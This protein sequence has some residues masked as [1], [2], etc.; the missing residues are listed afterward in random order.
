ML[1][2]LD[3]TDCRGNV[4]RGCDRRVVLLLEA[5]VSGWKIDRRVLAI[6]VDTELGLAL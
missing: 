3:A 5:L 6:N 2:L 4:L 1:V